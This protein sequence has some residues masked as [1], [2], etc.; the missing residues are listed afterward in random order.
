MLQAA[1]LGMSLSA[2]R[3]EA[4]ERLEAL[5]AKVAGFASKKH[6]LCGGWRSS[7]GKAK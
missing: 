6:A 2:S 1:S 7:W 3:K 4:K 5:G